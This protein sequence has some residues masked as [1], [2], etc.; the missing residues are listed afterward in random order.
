MGGDCSK[1]DFDQQEV[2]CKPTVTRSDLVANDI[3]SKALD[4]GACNNPCRALKA[5]G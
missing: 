4:C 3:I 2:N 1:E 5:E